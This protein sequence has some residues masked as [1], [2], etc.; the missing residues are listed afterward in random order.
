MTTKNKKTKKVT[1]KK[2]GGKPRVDF[3]WEKFN[4]ILQFMPQK[5][6]ASDIMGVSED[7]ID[8]RIKEMHNCTFKEYRERK[9]APVKMRL[10]KKA[11]DKAMNG[12]NTM[13]IFCLKNLCGWSDRPMD[14][15]LENQVANLVLNIPTN[16][17]E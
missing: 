6:V 11:I 5:D 13:L 2:K 4:A 16:N 8:R 1:T 17:R 9:M 15:G 14:K 12:D 7:T 10:V 3:D